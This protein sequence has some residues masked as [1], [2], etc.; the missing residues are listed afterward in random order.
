MNTRTKVIVGA[1]VAL[2]AI[3]LI[4]RF[5]VLSRVG[6]AGGWIFYLSLPIGGIVAL[7]LLLLRLRL[8]NFGE[9]PSAT[10]QH[11][12][13]NAAGQAPPPVSPPPAASQRLDELETLRN[14]GILSDTEYAAERARIIC[15]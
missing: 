13:H 8:L 6:V 9:S 12:Q 3:S 1:I 7:L 2:F 15:W 14:H 4:L 10:V 11:W 5:V